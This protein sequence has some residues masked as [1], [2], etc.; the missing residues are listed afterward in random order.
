MGIFSRFSDIINANIN[1]MLDKAEDPKKLVRL[2]IQEMEETLVELRA[3]AAKHIAEH[4]L[5]GIIFGG[6][7]QGEAMAANRIK[8]IRAA[9]FYSGPSE[10]IKDGFNGLLIQDAKNV[11]NIKQ[12][13]HQYFLLDDINEGLN[14]NFSNLRKN[15]EREMIKL[16]VISK[17]KEILYDN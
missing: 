12:V 11:D 4:N 9:V 7:G 10:I 2:L 17:Y 6:S 3:N 15:Y 13:L 1:T 14:Y 5:K 16:K 8:G